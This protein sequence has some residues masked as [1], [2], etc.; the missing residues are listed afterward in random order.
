MTYKC[1]GCGRPEEH[2]KCPAYG[3][4]FYMS[5]VPYSPEV[6]RL[7]AKF[8]AEVQQTVF[9][10]IEMIYEDKYDAHDNK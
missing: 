2:K 8:P 4:P 5:G 9:D 7:F 6:E 1:M 3:T 10:I